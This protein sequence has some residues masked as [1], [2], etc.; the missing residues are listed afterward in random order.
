MPR[1]I[2]D[3]ERLMEQKMIIV[4]KYSGELH[5]TFIN[6]DMLNSLF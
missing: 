3:R 1:G 2:S 5:G 6:E 4:K